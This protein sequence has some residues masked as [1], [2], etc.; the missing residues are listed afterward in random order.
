MR[1][2]FLIFFLLSS[3]TLSAQGTSRGFGF[4]ELPSSA[5]NAA[6]GEATVADFSSFVSAHIN[7]ALLTGVQS[8]SISI[9]HQQW[10]QDV[11]SNF[12][13][14]SIPTSFVNAG[15]SV[16]TTSIGGIEIRDIPGPPAGTFS[17]RSATIAALF[18]FQV[19]ADLS[20]GASLKHAYEKIYVDEAASVLFDIGAVYKLPF[21]GL[22]GGASIRHFGIADKMRD[23]RPRAP[24]QASFGLSYKNTLDQ[25][26]VLGVASVTSGTVSGSARSQFGVECAYANTVSLRLGY[27]SAFEVRGLSFGLGLSYG[28]FSFDYGSIPFSDGLGNGHLV[29]VGII[30]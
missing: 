11:Q 6:L 30:F 9:S 7:P 12:L 3:S 22:T 2:R 27:Q 23:L 16:S 21:E 8:F 19:D 14:V 24:T 18:G 20:V 15:L 13:F 1:P 10:I 17:A 4:L 26:D 5:R 25:F 28:L 29:S